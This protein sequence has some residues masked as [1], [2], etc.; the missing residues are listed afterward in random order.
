VGDDIESGVVVTRD[1]MHQNPVK[2][3]P[4]S[5]PDQWAWSSFRFYDL[6]DSSALTMDRLS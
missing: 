3:T 5:S 6:N 2:R 1:Y 4:V